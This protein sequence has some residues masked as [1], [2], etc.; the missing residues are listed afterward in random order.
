[1]SAKDDKD[2]VDQTGA[3]SLEQ[4]EPAA[5]DISG[6]AAEIAELKDKLLRALAETENVRRRAERDRQDAA[7]YA[8]TSFA[9]DLLAVSDNLRRALEHALPA[10]EQ[11][12]EIRLLIEGVEMTEREL[13]RVFE[14]HGIKR[15]NPEKGEK[16]DH[17]YH[18]AMYEVP[19]G[20]QPKGTIVQVMQ[21]GYALNGRLLRPAMVAVATAAAG[22]TGERVDQT[23]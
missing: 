10:A 13:L 2:Q 16:F 6:S 19:T 5:P 14:K 7:Q 22:S 18:Q 3:D 21:A 12:G 20:D 9:R 23:A 17:N 4:P 11:A 8:V 15:V 1:M